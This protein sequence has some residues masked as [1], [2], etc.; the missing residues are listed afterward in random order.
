MCLGRQLALKQWPG[1]CQKWWEAGHHI[2]GPW[3]LSEH[4]GDFMLMEPGALETELACSHR[5]LLQADHPYVSFSQRKKKI[6]SFYPRDLWALEPS[7][8]ISGEDNSLLIK[9]APIMASAL[10]CLA[11][12][13][14]PSPQA[15]PPPPKSSCSKRPRDPEK[16]TVL[17]YTGPDSPHWK[18]W[19]QISSQELALG[20]VQP[21]PS[22]Q[23][24]GPA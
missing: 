7:K 19:L 3:H 20:H 8:I 6:N 14:A 4:K 10:S 2:T 23:T 15:S 18:P 11:L 22:S 5:P 13:P 24:M 17:K 1:K 9:N 21:P 12:S 16:Q